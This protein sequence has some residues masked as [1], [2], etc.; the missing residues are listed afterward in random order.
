MVASTLHTLCSWAWSW[1]PQT[2]HLGPSGQIFSPDNF[3]L[4]QSGAGNTWAKAHYTEGTGL[5][6]WVLDIM[7]KEAESCD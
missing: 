2:V 3:V 6:A 5:V 7:K 4:H 1:A